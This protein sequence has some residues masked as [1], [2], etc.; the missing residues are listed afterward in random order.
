MKTCIKRSIAVAGIGAVVYGTVIVMAA[1]SAWN[2]ASVPGAAL[3][4]VL[5]VAALVIGDVWEW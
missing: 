3:S 4:G 5:G 2:F 1:I